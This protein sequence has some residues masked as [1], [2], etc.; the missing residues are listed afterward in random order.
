MRA[1]TMGALTAGKSVATRA[2][3]MD[4]SRAVHLVASKA[5]K[6]AEKTVEMKVLMKAWMSVE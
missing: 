4:I 1:G 2:D 6:M 5:S 3:E